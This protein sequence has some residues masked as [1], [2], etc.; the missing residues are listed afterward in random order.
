[1]YPLL[2]KFAP[3]S[4][5]T[6]GLMI[7]VGF[8]AALTAV[9][10]LSSRIGLDPERM[11][12]FVF[13]FMVV[14]LLGAR[15]LYVMTRWEDFSVDPLAIFRIWEGG[16]VFYGG[17]LA[18]I[19]FAVWLLRKNRISVWNGVDIFLPALTISHAF[20]RL[21][22]V[23][24]GCCYGKVTDLPWGIRLSSE[25]VDLSHRGVPLHPV[26]LYEAFLLLILFAGLVWLFPRR[27][28]EGQVGLVYLFAYPVIRGFTEE[29]RGD[30]VRGFVIDGVLSTSQAISIVFILI[31]SGFMIARLRSLGDSSK[32]LK[33]QARA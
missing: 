5:H 25:L 8:F 23:A 1:V 29:F 33:K 6:Y 15:T 32:S 28:F 20:G 10:R 13:W 21:G 3:V 7:A 4:I 14:G 30:V 19:P 22:C 12:D 11:A 31:A 17:P 2:L 9:R 26:Q 27:K 18:V 24:A 16:L